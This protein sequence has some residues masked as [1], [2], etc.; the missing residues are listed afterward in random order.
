MDEMRCISISTTGDQN[1]EELEDFF[2]VLR[3]ESTLGDSVRLDNNFTDAAGAVLSNA[4]VVI[5]SEREDC[6]YI[7]NG[8]FNSY[9]GLFNSLE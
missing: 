1:V 8:L 5:I 2:V 4:T 7:K 3:Q 9:N 6:K